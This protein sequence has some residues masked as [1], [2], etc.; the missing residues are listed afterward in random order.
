MVLVDVAENGESAISEIVRRTGFPQS[1]VSA[2]VSRLRDLGAIRTQ[3][4]PIDGRRTLVTVAPGMTQRAAGRALPIDDA[5]AT[6]LEG[7]GPDALAEVNAA[8]ELLTQLLIPNVVRH[9]R[10]EASA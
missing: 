7:A 2:S 3:V 6:S 8:L 4:D 9:M 5:L 1:H 10:S